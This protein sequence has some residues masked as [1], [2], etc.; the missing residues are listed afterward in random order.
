MNSPVSWIGPARPAVRITFRFVMLGAVAMLAFPTST[1]HAARGSV[2]EFR[3]CFKVQKNTAAA[4][5]MYNLDMDTKRTDLGPAFYKE[6]VRRKYLPS[7]PEDPGQGPNTSA[8][9]R[10]ADQE[11]S[12]DLNVYC[13]IHGSVAGRKKGSLPRPDFARIYR[14]SHPGSSKRAAADHPPRAPHQLAIAAAVARYNADTKTSQKFVDGKL[15]NEL[16]RRGYFKSLSPAELHRMLCFSYQGQIANAIML[17]N[18]EKNTR[19]E[20][21][22]SA[23]LEAVTKEGYLDEAPIAPDP[24]RPLACTYHVVEEGSGVSCSVHGTFIPPR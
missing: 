11:L 1:L 21:I 6:L 24:A 19:L 18:V 16:V 8:H 9:F 22:D 10:Y 7:L 23:F 17:H 12:D 5:E 13:T 3:A 2:D 14:E 4:V 15:L 20:V